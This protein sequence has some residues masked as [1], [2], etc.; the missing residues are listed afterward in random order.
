[1]K[2][3]YLLSTLWIWHSLC[4]LAAVLSCVVLLWPQVYLP[5]AYEK[6]IISYA[7]TIALCSL[8]GSLLLLAITA[9]IMLLRLHYRQAL[10]QALSWVGQWVAV[11]AIFTALAY[12]A[13]VPV[14]KLKIA[15]HPDAPPQ[16]EEESALQPS[17]I[18]TGPDALFILIPQERFAGTATDTVEQT[19]HL[20]LLEK[21]H[22]K[23]LE[24]YLA[25]SPRWTLYMDDD[26]FYT[27]P[28]HVVMSPP[29]TGSGIQGLVHVAFRHL[30][31]GDP[32]PAG[33]TI[34]KPGA[35]MP[36]RPEGSEQVADLAVDLGKNH[37]LL[38]AWRGTSHTETAHRALNSAIATVDALLQPL[39]E[40]PSPDTVH[41]LLEGKRNMVAEEP[42]LLLCQ[43]PSQYGAYQ[44]EVYVNPGEAGT[45]ILRIADRKSGAT[46]RFLYCPALYSANP[47]ELFRHDIPGSISS[48]HSSMPRQHSP[49]VGHIPGLLPEK[50]P[51]F[52]IKQGE[53][54]QFFDVVIEVWFQPASGHKLRR[55]LLS[56]IYRVQACEAPTLPE[57]K[58][59][60]EPSADA[61][62]TTKEETP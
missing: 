50:A 7:G 25:K 2:R 32:V 31:E 58:P 47:G 59:H 38:L 42:N 21:E 51:L 46:L 16:E 54:H 52:A 37:Y 60:E 33:Y 18:L 62:S 6:Q 28:G 29:G 44:A 19:P 39:A 55:K 10:G 22:S 24:L 13:D 3:P 9:F 8:L 48:H 41:R 23:L 27:K 12:L 20:T 35:P 15:A 49:L 53:A 4:C 61:P 43:P 56:R 40:S 5:D 30:V 34:V 45:L 26:T 17:D 36:A 14:P 1:M 57:L 11:G